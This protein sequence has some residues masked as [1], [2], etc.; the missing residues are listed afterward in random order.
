MVGYA[1][2]LAK[3]PRHVRK[4]CLQKW[5]P[6]CLSRCGVEL[7]LP[8]V[9]VGDTE[10][11]ITDAGNV[12]DIH[13][14]EQSDD[15]QSLHETSHD[16]LNITMH[17]M[18]LNLALHLADASDI[19]H[20]LEQGFSNEDALNFLIM[21]APWK[22]SV[23]LI[24]PEQQSFKLLEELHSGKLQ[25]VDGRFVDGSFFSTLETAITVGQPLV[26]HRVCQDVDPAILTIMQQAKIAS[27][28]QGLF[29]IVHMCCHVTEPAV[30]RTLFSSFV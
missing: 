1:V 20:L 19:L 3:L 7:H 13:V 9:T 8:Q 28:N 11:P 5:W 18:A 30:L 10:F 25:F 23:V 16:G 15:S 4:D 14:L 21:K 12:H 29:H 2:Y 27:A 22:Q 26:V 6:A 24:D 17:E